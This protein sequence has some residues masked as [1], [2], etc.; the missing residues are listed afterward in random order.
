MPYSLYK[1]LDIKDYAPTSVSFQMADKIKKWQ[2]GMIEDVLLRI[3][4]H[5]IPT[6]FIILDMPEDDKLYIILGRSFLGTAG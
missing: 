6:N 4:Q 2:V 5:V 1:K 3:Y